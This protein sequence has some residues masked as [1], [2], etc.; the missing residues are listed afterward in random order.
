VDENGNIHEDKQSTCSTVYNYFVKLF[1]NEIGEPNDIAFADVQRKV[2][3]DMNRDLLA[4]FI[5]E[6]VQKKK[7][8]FSIGYLKAPGP[9]GLHVV[10]Y[11]RF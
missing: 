5:E 6:E 4:D 10:F 3:D 7:A 11:K 8:L 9:D 2:T 1:T